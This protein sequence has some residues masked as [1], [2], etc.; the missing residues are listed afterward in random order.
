MHPIQVKQVKEIILVS[1]DVDASR[2]IYRDVLGLAMPD[3]PDRLNLARIGSQYLGAAQRGVMAHPGFSGGVHL[4][5]ELDTADFARAVDHLRRHG[6]QVTIR[7]Q[8]PGYMDTPDS[9]GA[10]F[11]DPDANL[12]ELWAP[13]SAWDGG[14]GPGPRAGSS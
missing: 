2:R 7:A 9:V 11:L 5:L 10:Y 4:G 6:I 1:D 14:S 3:P 12:V 13:G 8:R